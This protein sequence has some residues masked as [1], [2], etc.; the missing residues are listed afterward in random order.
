MR[1]SD[2]QSGETLRCVHQRLG[3]VAQAIMLGSTLNDSSLRDDVDQLVR[4]AAR[5][6]LHQRALATLA[7]ERALNLPVDI[8]EVRRGQLGGAFAWM[9]RGEAQPL[10]QPT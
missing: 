8:P 5:A 9:A 4:T 6:T 7:S 1:I 10:E 2:D 3:A